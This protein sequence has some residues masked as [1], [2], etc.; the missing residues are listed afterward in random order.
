MKASSY[1][2]N[3]FSYKSR[4]HACTFT[5]P[6]HSQRCH[7]AI[8]SLCTFLCTGAPYWYKTEKHYRKQAC[9]ELPLIR[10]SACLKKNDGLPLH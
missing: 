7:L 10:L 8:E 5:A 2:V 3:S 4:V 6:V 9:S 1:S